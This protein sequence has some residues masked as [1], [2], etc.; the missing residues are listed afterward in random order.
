M[1]KHRFRSWAVLTLSLL[2]C[3]GL[4]ACGGSQ[5]GDDPQGSSGKL[6]RPKKNQPITFSQEAQQSLDA[7]QMER[8]QEVFAAAILAEREEGDSS[9]LSAL[10]NDWDPGFAAQW[11]FVLEITEEHTIGDYGELYCVVPLDSTCTFVVRQVTWDT[12]GNGSNPIFGDT[13]YR[14]SAG[15]PFLLYVTHGDWA[16]EK[17]VCVEI[18]NED[19]STWTWFPSYGEGCIHNNPLDENGNPRILDFTH[20]DEFTE[21]PFTPDADW[22]A[23][24][25]LGLADSVWESDNGWAMWLA[26]D[27]GASQG[28]GGMVLY[29][30][31]EDDGDY[32]LSRYCHGTWWMEDGCLYLDAYNDRGDMVGGAFPVLISPSGEQL[33]IMQAADGSVPPFFAVGQTQAILTFSEMP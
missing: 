32:F 11:P 25:D 8:N 24:T 29:E 30:P 18:T 2:L 28:S 31:M 6:D 3:L 20:L 26:Y 22:G 17:N 9:S 21:M 7:L 5:G 4:V 23:P 10:L 19:G 33:L 13:I 12:E 14:A 15:Q 16:E 1:K 27:A